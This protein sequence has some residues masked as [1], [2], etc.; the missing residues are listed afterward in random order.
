MILNV[1]NANDMYLL[2]WNFA[3]SDTKYNV[4]EKKKLNV[5]VKYRQWYYII[6]VVLYDRI[7]QEP[8]Q[9]SKSQFTDCLC[10]ELHSHITSF[11]WISHWY[12]CAGSL[13]GF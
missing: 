6:F 9:I 12:P 8:E 2:I 13:L 7:N 3:I 1:K 11:V 4:I 5:T 10:L